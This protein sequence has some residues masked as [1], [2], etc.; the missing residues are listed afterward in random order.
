[1]KDRNKRILS[2][3]TSDSSGGAAR[4][5]YRIHQAV[6]VLGEDSKM[7]VKQKGTNDPSVLCVDDFVPNNVFYKGFDW[8]RNKCKN[9]WQHNIWRKY[10]DRESF[11]MSDLRS[12]DI[13]GALK[14]IDYDVLHLHWINQR[15]LPLE[16]LPKDKP[17]IWTLHDSWPFCGICHLPFNCVSY[18]SE[19]GKCPALHS[20][21]SNDISHQIWQKKRQIYEKLDLHIV[22]PSNWIATCA[23]HSSL[24]KDFPIDV[25]PNCVDTNVFS[26]VDHRKKTHGHSILFG[27][28]NAIEDQNKGFK[29]LIEALDVLDPSIKDKLNLT[30]FGTRNSFESQIGGIQVHNLGVL[31]DSQEIVSAY[32]S[33][34]VTVVPSLSENLSCTIMESLSCG[35]PVVAFRIGGNSD[36]IDHMKNGYLAK[37]NDCLDL[38]NGIIWCIRNNRDSCLSLNARQKVMDC[39]TP[40]T[41]GSMYANLYNNIIS[42]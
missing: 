21:D 40:N 30:V 36:L 32:H 2:I 20:M 1:M 6:R 38:A 19:C 24:F 23:K 31:R 25:I 15:F 11:Y 7:F 27:A 10:P 9:K 34:D 8:F 18:Y 14:R 41:V 28:M 13:G 29:L 35:T 22:A 42:K 39:F 26:F 3:C 5:A 17:I 33:A 12:M 16:L 37:E 4:A